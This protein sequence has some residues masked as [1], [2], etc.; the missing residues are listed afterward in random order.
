MKNMFACFLQASYPGQ[1]GPSGR[2]RIRTVCP[3]KC[4][5][6]ARQKSLSPSHCFGFNSNSDDNTFIDIRLVG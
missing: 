6:F 1:P 2:V 4:K 3:R 5:I